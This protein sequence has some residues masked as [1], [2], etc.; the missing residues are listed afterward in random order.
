MPGS[1][2]GL[3]ALLFAQQEPEGQ[4][5]EEGARDHDPFWCGEECPDEELEGGLLE[6]LE[7]EDET[8][9]HGYAD[10]DELGIFSEILQTHSFTPLRIRLHEI[11]HAQRRCVNMHVELSD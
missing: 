1:K 8:E 10:K 3:Y 7:D 9:Y 5:D 2:K 4:P 11:W 6:V